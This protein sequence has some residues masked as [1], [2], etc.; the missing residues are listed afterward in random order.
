MI[1]PSS[2]YENGTCWDVSSS[3]ALRRDG[4]SDPQT[5]ANMVRFA[6]QKYGSG[7]NYVTGHSS[8]AMLTQV[9]G[10][11]YPDLFVAG[12]EYSGVPSTCFATGKPIGQDWNPDCAQGKYNETSQYWVQRARS[13]YPV[14]C[15]WRAF[16]LR[17]RLQA[18]KANH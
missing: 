2:P 3:A 7:K 4:G 16:L 8:G 6:M 5:V 11:E 13:T 12:A 15:Q 14:S 10:T 17:S 1:F 18:V 9:M